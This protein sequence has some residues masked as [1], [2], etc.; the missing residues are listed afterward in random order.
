MARTKRQ[1]T[2]PSVDLHVRWMIRRDFGDVM[3]IEREEFANPYTVDELTEFMERRNVIGMVAEDFRNDDAGR[4]VGFMVYA[5]H[6]SR[7]ELLDFAVDGWSQG[8]GIG[9]AMMNKLKGKL[10]TDRRRYI[11]FDVSENNTDGQLFLKALGFVCT[12]IRYGEFDDG[13]DAYRFEW[14]V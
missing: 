9:T 12:E 3:R 11:E 13:T 5:F 4:I 14:H 1:P 8:Q 10:H 2:K 7:I 6:K